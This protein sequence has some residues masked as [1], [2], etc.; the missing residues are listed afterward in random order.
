[1]SNYIEDILEQFIEQVGVTDS[2]EQILTS[3]NRQ[4][5]KGVALTDRQYELVKKLLQ[6]E[7]N[8]DVPNNI[9]T[10]LPIR[11]ID[12]SKYIRIVDTLDV[13]K[14]RIYESYKGNWQWIKIRFPFSKKTIIDL[15]AVSRNHRDLY[16]HEKGTHE[17]YFKLT[18][19]VVLDVVETFSK[20]EFEIENIIIEYYNQIKEIKDNPKQ[21]LPG[22]WDGKLLNVDVNVDYTPL[23]LLDRKRQLG[24]THV[25]VNVP[26]GLVGTICSREHTEINIDPA[27]HSI[28][29]IVNALFD[30]NRFPILV[31]VD[32]N[33]EYDQMT[34]VYNAFKNLVPDE[35]Q[36]ALFRVATNNNEYT[37]NDFIKD[38]KLNNWLDKDTQIVYISK[39]KLPKLLLTE[40]WKPQCVLS[41]TSYREHSTV[42]TY[43][44]DTCDLVIYHDKEKSPFRSYNFW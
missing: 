36:C 38:H 28:D 18:E 40:D 27:A 15:E 23:Q 20:K 9:D 3:I 29:K 12:R 7:Y 41:L 1:M 30:L 17:H 19:T 44:N 42:R 4:C 10:R 39:N 32:N 11:Q 21:Y 8:V 25:D 34:V 26:A 16:Y 13:M 22:F 24:L 35:K 37:V 43:I 6:E 2:N 31:C 33:T 14:D 5:K